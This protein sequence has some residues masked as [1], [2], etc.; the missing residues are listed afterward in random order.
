MRMA[1]SLLVAPAVR[2]LAWDLATM[3]FWSGERLHKV[4]PAN[5]KECVACGQ[6]ATTHHLFFTCELSAHILNLT[7]LAIRAS[8]LPEIRLTER[9]YLLINP[10]RGETDATKMKAIRAT[11]AN[12][13]NFRRQLIY[14]PTLCFSSDLFLKVFQDSHK[15]AEKIFIRSGGSG[16]PWFIVRGDLESLNLSLPIHIK[17]PLLKHAPVLL[18]QQMEARSETAKSFDKLLEDHTALGSSQ[19]K[20]LEK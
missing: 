19:N 13:L 5:P 20:R 15:H 18:N 7:R 8:G 14:T 12:S 9:S 16:Y 6:L 4:D 10:P 1:T 17:S 2:N 11:I 3:D